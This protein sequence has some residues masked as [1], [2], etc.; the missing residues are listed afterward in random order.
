MKDRQ[1]RLHCTKNEVFHYIFTE[2]ILNGKLHVLCI[3]TSTSAT[4][5]ECVKILRC[6]F[7]TVCYVNFIKSNLLNLGFIF[8]GRLMQ[9]LP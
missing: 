8:Y 7:S 3:V 2:E 5:C 4:F 1:F 6:D 9:K